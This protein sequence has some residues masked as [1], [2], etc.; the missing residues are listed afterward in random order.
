MSVRQSFIIPAPSLLDLWTRDNKSRIRTTSLFLSPTSLS[1]WFRESEERQDVVVAAA[2]PFPLSCAQKTCTPDPIQE[3]SQ[4]S[5]CC[6]APAFHC[7]ITASSCLAECFLSKGKEDLGPCVLPALSQV[8]GS[9]IQVNEHSTSIEKASGVREN[10]S[11]C[12]RRGKRRHRGI[13]KRGLQT[14]CTYMGRHTNAA[15]REA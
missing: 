6:V 3:H 7:S 13:E 9:L 1:S 12:C 11:F 5:R 4:H 10:Q 8:R 14:R 2:V 15:S